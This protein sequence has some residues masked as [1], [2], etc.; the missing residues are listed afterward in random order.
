M[1]PPFLLSQPDRR[2][3]R[4][5]GWAFLKCRNTFSRC[6]SCYRWRRFLPPLSRRSCGGTDQL[7]CWIFLSLRQKH[8]HF[9]WILVTA[10]ISWWHTLSQTLNPRMSS[11]QRWRGSPEWRRSL[12][13]CTPWFN[14]SIFLYSMIPSTCTSTTIQTLNKGTIVPLLWK[15]IRTQHE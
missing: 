6:R 4:R 11:L 8:R 12:S 5:H 15:K 14:I 9:D 1:S 7:Q 3:G 13:L 10:S 2:P